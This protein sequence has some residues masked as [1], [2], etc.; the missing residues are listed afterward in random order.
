[1]RRVPQHNTCRVCG[2]TLANKHA[3]CMCT[4]AASSR[5]LQC[6]LGV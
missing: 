5:A 3:D 4:D 1:V 6:S 2:H